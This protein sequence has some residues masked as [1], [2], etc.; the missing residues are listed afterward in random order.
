[1]NELISL[2]ENELRNTRFGSIQFDL[3]IHDGQI[4]CINITRTTRHNII[5]IKNK[6]V[7]YARAR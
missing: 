2:I 1:M 6:K 4:R 3:I 7:E 5:P